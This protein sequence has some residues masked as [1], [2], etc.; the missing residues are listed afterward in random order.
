MESRT[1]HPILES[2]R[3]TG[4]LLAYVAGGIFLALFAL[5]ALAS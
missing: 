3:A 5:Q 2:E 1:T 4:R